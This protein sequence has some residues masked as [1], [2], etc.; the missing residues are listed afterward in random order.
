M[1]PPTNP[2]EVR[3]FLGLAGYYRKFVPKY[4]DIARPLTN[5]TKQEVPYEWTNRCQQTF[6]FF[7]EMLLKEPIVKIP[8]PQEAIYLV[9]RCKQV[10]LGMCTNTTL[11]ITIC[12]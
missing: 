3:Q 1:P 9:H 4:A 8:R 2:K 7:K 6:E 10:C 5:L 12:T 11:T